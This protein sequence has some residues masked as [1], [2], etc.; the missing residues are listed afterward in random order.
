MTSSRDDV[1]IF[2]VVPSHEALAAFGEPGWEN[3]AWVGLCWYTAVTNFA[4]SRSEYDTT[5]LDPE[6]WPDVAALRDEIVHLS[7]ATGV[8]YDEHKGQRVAYMKL[9]AVPED[10]PAVGENQDLMVVQGGPVPGSCWLTL[11]RIPH[12]WRVWGFG[13]RLTADEVV[14]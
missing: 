3:P 9:F 2:A 14:L 7:L 6:A 12:G 5:V 10:A 11:V 13:A 4:G 1:P 8:E